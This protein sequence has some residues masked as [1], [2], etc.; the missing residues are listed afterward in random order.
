MVSDALTRRA[1]GELLTPA[2]IQALGHTAVVAVETIG[3]AAL[4][5]D[6]AADPRWPSD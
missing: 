1:D 3:K 5:I 2:D 4:G 6:L